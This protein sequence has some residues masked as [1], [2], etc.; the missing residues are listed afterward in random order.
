M[1]INISLSS[2]IDILHPKNS[3]HFINKNKEKKDLKDSFYNVLVGRVID[4]IFMISQVMI[5]KSTI[6]KNL[7]TDPR[8]LQLATQQIAA[9][10]ALIS[11]VFMIASLI[12]GIIFFYALQYAFHLVMK[13]FG[14]NG[15]I[16]G[17]C[18]LVSLLYVCFVFINLVLSSALL[19]HGPIDPSAMMQGPTDPIS[20]GISFVAL[21]LFVY[22]LYRL[23]EIIKTVYNLSLFGAIAALLG[24]IAVF[25]AVNSIFLSIASALLG[26]ALG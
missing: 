19:L 18:Y 12:I 4:L 21:A 6:Q 15:N 5:L 25:F 24:F 11:P 17:Q 9:A 8:Q 13:L 26:G 22:L 23:Y 14:K 7:P 1:A 16:H 20:I 10:D 3:S 2:Y